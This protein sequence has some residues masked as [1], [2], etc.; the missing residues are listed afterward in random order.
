M[1]DVILLEEVSEHACSA[2][3]VYVGCY[4]DDDGGR[5]GEWGAAVGLEDVEVGLGVRG[6]GV[7][8]EVR[9]WDVHH[10]GCGHKSDQRDLSRTRRVM[11]RY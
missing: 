1:H 2:E 10:R 6:T 4:E 8:G 9:G 3:G 5:R 7:G 11:S